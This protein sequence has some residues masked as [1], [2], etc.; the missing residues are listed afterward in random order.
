MKR[1]GRTYPERHVQ[2]PCGRERHVRL[3]DSSVT[4]VC[5]CVGGGVKEER[6]R[7]REREKREMRC[8]A[9]N[10][11]LSACLCLSP[12]NS[13]CIRDFGAWA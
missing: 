12:E 9:R 1:E 2:R 13:E 4:G 3:E 6:E 7:G 10:T 11:S 8:E 5:V